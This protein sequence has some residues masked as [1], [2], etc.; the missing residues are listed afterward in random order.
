MLQHL[1]K[2]AL[3]LDRDGV[4]NTRIP[5]AYIGRVADWEP[6]PHLGEALALL[7]DLAGRIVVVTNQAGIGKGLV[8]ADEV[9]AVHRHMVQFIGDAGGRIDRVY[10]CPHR[11]EARCRC[12]KPRTGMAF[13]ALA[14]YPDIDFRNSIMVGDSLTDIQFGRTLGMTTVLIEGKPEDAAD[15]ARAKVD[16]RFERLIDFARAWHLNTIIL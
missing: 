15:L 7:S 13:Q 12:R 3:F 9:D 16:F 11:K 14:D 10:T 8:G 1:I 6:S 4:I 5:D 2:P